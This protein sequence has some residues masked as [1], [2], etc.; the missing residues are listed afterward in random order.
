MS[1]KKLLTRDELLARVLANDPILQ[2]QNSDYMQSFYPVVRFD[3]IAAGTTLTL[4]V[5]LNG[6]SY[7]ISWV[8]VAHNIAGSTTNMSD[9]EVQLSQPS[10][11]VFV[12][13]PV[14]GSA[15]FPTVAAEQFSYFPKPLKIKASERLNVLVNNISAIALNVTI[16]FQALTDVRGNI[17]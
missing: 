3:N 9:F 15:L 1:P 11:N 6:D 12:Q 14:V 2:A 17:G 16:A 8:G 7:I 10:G 13:I 5:Q 4:P